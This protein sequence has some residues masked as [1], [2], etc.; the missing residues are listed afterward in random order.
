MYGHDEPDR[1]TKERERV[2]DAFGL[3]L[4][5]RNWSRACSRIR[6]VDRSA[7]GGL[8]EHL[9]ASRHVQ[10]RRRARVGC[11]PVVKTRA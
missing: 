6:P 4:P 5:G 10:V 2:E 3:E 7:A 8:G 9:L 11:W 1:K